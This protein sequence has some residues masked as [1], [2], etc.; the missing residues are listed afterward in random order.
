MAENSGNY[1]RIAKNTIMLYFRMLLIMFVSLY[2]VRALLSAL[3]QED[4]GLYN[5]I[6]GIVVMFSFLSNVLS[7]ASQRYFAYEIG[8]EDYHKLSKTYSVMLI[9]YVIFTI[10]III[11]AETIGLWFLHNKMTIPPNRLFAAEFVYQFSIFSFCWKILTSPHQAIIIANERMGVYAY[12]GIAEVFLQLILVVLLS[13]IPGDSL[14][15]YSVL[16]FAITF[17]INSCYVIYSRKKYRGI[18]F[19]R[20]WDKQLFSNVVSYS[21]WTLLGTLAAVARGQGINIVLNVYFTPIVNASRGIAHNVES[22]VTSFANSFYTAVRPQIIKYYAQRDFESCY[23]LVFRSSKFS[24][25]LLMLFI[26][27]IIAYTPDILSLWLND[28]PEFSVVFVRLILL[29]ALIDSLANPLITFN[30]ATGNVKMYQIVVGILVLCNIPFSILAFE[31]GA[32]PTAAFIV[33]IAIAFLAMLARLEVLY[34]Q[35]RFPVK[36][37][38]KEV[39][40]QISI[41]SVVCS[42]SSMA[43][44]RLIGQGSPFTSILGILSIMTMSIIV[45]IVI[46]T[47][48]SEKVS[49]VQFVKSKIK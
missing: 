44:K 30:Q 48:K 5:V 15:V 4:Y 24:Y 42:I 11:L 43:L 23:K 40:Y 37:Y 41:V 19:I 21:S 22:A 10:I 32:S 20:E 36:R 7:S 13:R 2:T 34:K 29:S 47:D 45:S 12:V 27:P 3:G 35:H 9:L 16:M 17:T 33:S 6:G 39:V 31:L 46:G 28:Y 38:I 18:K 49:V 26:I 1:K 25:Y 8:K 14:I